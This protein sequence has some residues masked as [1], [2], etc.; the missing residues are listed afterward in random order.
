MTE[1]RVFSRGF[2]EQ[3][4]ALAQTSGRNKTAIASDLGIDVNM[5]CRW[6]CQAKKVEL[7]GRN[8]NLE[9]ITI[10]ESVTSVGKGTFLGWTDEQ[11]IY[12]PFATLSA[13]NAPAAQGGC[14]TGWRAG[15][16]AV[17]RSNISAQIHP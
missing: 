5:L 13:A 17:I 16:N 15:N 9:S 11:T 12:I 7:E 1:R 3:A 6:Q 2:K 14:G 4:I 8:I 10:P